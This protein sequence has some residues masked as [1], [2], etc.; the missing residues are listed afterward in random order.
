MNIA[1]LYKYVFSKLFNTLFFRN[2]LR[3]IRRILYVIHFLQGRCIK[4]VGV[5]EPSMF[6][7]VLKDNA[8]RIIRNTRIKQL[9]FFENATSY[10][11]DTL[12]PNDLF[13]QVIQ[14]FNYPMLNFLEYAL[15]I[16]L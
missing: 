13:L 15:R 2:V 6:N 4:Y 16:F 1:Y 9:R 5:D 11:I 12:P 7:T 3:I 14:V 10:L 8:L